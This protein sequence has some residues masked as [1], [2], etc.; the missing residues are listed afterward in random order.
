MGMVVTQHVQLP[1]S[2]VPLNPELL[3]RIDQ[4]AVALRLPT[5]IR[6]GQ[7]RLGALRVMAQVGERHDFSDDSLAAVRM[8]QQYP[9]TLGG[10]LTFAVATNRVSVL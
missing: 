2:G 4:K 1:R 8:T 10:I 9:T 7:K 3:H 5:R 6:Q